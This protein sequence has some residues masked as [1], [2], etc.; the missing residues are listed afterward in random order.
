M[1]TADPGTEKA[2]AFWRKK[3]G[4]RFDFK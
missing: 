2:A 1:H 4:F 3:G